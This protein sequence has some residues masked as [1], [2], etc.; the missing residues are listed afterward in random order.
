MSGGWTPPALI[1]QSRAVAASTVWARRQ[2]SRVGSVEISED[3]PN[4]NKQKLLI[5][6]LIQ[7]G[8]SHCHLNLAVSN[9]GIREASFMMLKK[10]WGGLRCALIGANSEY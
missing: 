6:N 3:H 10:K 7:Q 9:T 5:Q 8:I 2:I 1:R 4:E